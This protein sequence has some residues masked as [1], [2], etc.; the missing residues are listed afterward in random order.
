MAT[1]HSQRS[2]SNRAVYLRKPSASS[3]SQVVD[4]CELLS[5]SERN[6][7]DCLVPKKN[8]YSLSDVVLPLG[9]S[10]EGKNEN[11]VERALQK[12]FPAYNLKIS[13]NRAVP[14]MSALPVRETAP[15]KRADV[16]AYIELDGPKKPKKLALQIEV[17]SSHM[18]NTV[19]KAIHGAADILRLLRYTDEAFDSIT[20]FVFPKKE[21]PT[22][23]G[24][25]TVSY[26]SLCFMYIIEW[27]PDVTTVWDE[28]GKV[29]DD[30]IDN[31]PILPDV[32]DVHK[33]YSIILSPRQLEEFEGGAKQVKSQHHVM[34]ESNGKLFKIVNNKDEMLKLLRLEHTCSFACQFR[35]F[36]V[37]VTQE[38]NIIHYDK[39][40]Y[41][42]LEEDQACNYL[43]TLSQK[44]C[45]ALEE[46]HGIG[47]AHGDLRLPN[48]CF[49]SVYDAVLIDMDRCTR[50]NENKQSELCVQL[51]D[52]SCM[53]QMP[54]TIDGVLNGK[55]LDYIQLGWLLVWMLNCE[56][57]YHKRKWEEQPQDI[58]SDQFLSELVCQGVYRREALE[59]SLVKDSVTL[60]FSSLFH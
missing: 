34:V 21:E 56:A 29:L 41:G 10:E 4:V 60:P 58:Q 23:V 46:L 16:N 38:P 57:D 36:I 15:V 31:L 45:A 52:K 30:N 24:K 2:R 40:P 37:P 7:S 11:V 14:G 48:V 3:A 27:L 42:P 13:V 19:S 59:S 22:C 26:E 9:I 47:Y 12:R 44:V 17:H 6:G 51:G 49:S 55:R 39:V 18:R 1:R 33:D 32:G 54:E 25:I 20:V 35:H 5:Y 53:Y 43:R 50:I 28:I 8:Y